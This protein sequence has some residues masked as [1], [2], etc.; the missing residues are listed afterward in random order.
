MQNTT[1]YTPS[2]TRWVV[3]TAT[4]LVVVA[5]MAMGLAGA[6]TT[7]HW[8]TASTKPSAIPLTA[9]M[10]APR[11]FAPLNA[12]PL[13][14]P[15]AVASSASEAQPWPQATVPPS[16][17]DVP[18]PASGFLWGLGSLLS[19][20]GLAAWALSRQKLSPLAPLPPFAPTSEPSFAM[21]AVAGEPASFADRTASESE[22]SETVVRVMKERY[23]D[24]ETTR[25]VDSWR[26]MEA[27]VTHSETLGAHP[28]MIQKASFY[29]EGLTAK[30]KPVWENADIAWASVLESG[31]TKI[32][33]ELEEVINMTPEE[34]ADCGSMGWVSPVEY[35]AA[36]AYGPDWQTLGL[37]ERGKYDE[38]NHALFPNTCQLLRDAEVPCMEACFAKM[39]AGTEILPHT[40]GCNFLLTGHLGLKIPKTGCSLNVGDSTCKWK[41]GEMLLFDSSFMHEAFNTS[42]ED[43][44]VLLIR[45]WHPELTPVEV[46]ALNFLFDCIDNRLSEEKAA[47]GLTPPSEAYTIEVAEKSW[48]IPGGCDTF[49]TSVFG[50]GLT[51]WDIDEGFYMSVFKGGQVF[52]EP[53]H[54]YEVRK[55]AITISVPEE[56]YEE[57]E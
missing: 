50:P 48:K 49:D 15:A 35:G 17:S 32:K 57:E 29:V 37:V 13:S 26:R 8:T 22:F 18:S 42:D 44:Y 14:I 20:V 30:P 6:P 56:E 38:A 9:P 7:Q 39:P 10:A 21:A 11:A 27:G 3:A 1:P 45:V 16:S 41:D 53:G 43:R 5:C 31:W 12:A 46:Q 47:S 19:T 28:L 33:D 55:V 23:G 4:S 40:D 52:V 54:R 24:E 25:V 51:L 34:L 2:Q 36:P